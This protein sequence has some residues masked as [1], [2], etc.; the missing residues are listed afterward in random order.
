MSVVLSLL[1]FLR[2]YFI[3]LLVSVGF[4]CSVFCFPTSSVLVFV[5]FGCA[6]SGFVV[7]VAPRSALLCCLNNGLFPETYM[8]NIIFA[9]LWASCFTV[10]C[11]RI[12]FRAS[13]GTFVSMVFVDRLFPAFDFAFLPSP[14]LYLGFDNE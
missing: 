1:P 5:A 4:C 6:R 12:S 9:I 10:G 3:V 14:S 13:I 7:L 2:L 8:L 11:G